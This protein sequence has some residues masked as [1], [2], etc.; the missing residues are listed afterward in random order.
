VSGPGTIICITTLLGQRH[1]IIVRASRPPRRP[2]GAAAPPSE[3]SDS[4]HHHDSSYPV[5]LNRN[6]IIKFHL[7]PT[8]SAWNHPE[9]RIAAAVAWGTVSSSQPLPES[10]WRS[11]RRDTGRLQL[12]YKFT[13]NCQRPPPAGKKY[14]R[15]SQGQRQPAPSLSFMLLAADDS[16]LPVTIIMM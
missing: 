13:V 4:S 15:L 7:S 16:D 14:E 8:R 2:L 9:T 5:G 6:S 1:R 3:S 12:V 11:K 10:C